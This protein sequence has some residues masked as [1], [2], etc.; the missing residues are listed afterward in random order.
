[1]EVSS[2]ETSARGGATVQLLSNQ[3]NGAKSAEYSIES[4]NPPGTEADLEED[5][6]F[7]LPTIR[8]AVDRRLPKRRLLRYIAWLPVWTCFHLLNLVYRSWDVEGFRHDKKPAK[9]PGKLKK[10]RLASEKQWARVPPKFA[11]RKMLVLWT[12]LTWGAC[13]GFCTYLILRRSSIT[14]IEKVQP[15][16]CHRRK[17]WQTLVLS[18]PLNV[19]G[20]LLVSA[21]SF[22][23]Q[24]LMSPTR[25]ELD[26]A[27]GHGKILTI[28]SPSVRNLRNMSVL[29]ATIWLCLTF[30]S[31]PFHV[32]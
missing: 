24:I 7:P 29:K 5:N 14:D 2:T 18:L 9:P 25:K 19:L 6:D 10:F 1:M 23:R 12:L 28:A 15:L 16:A 32:L 13:A 20:S 31:F 30:T 8:Q 26:R 4:T 3:D 21:S 11:W 27:H 22:T 17:L